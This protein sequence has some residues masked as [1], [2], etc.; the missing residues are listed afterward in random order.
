M[1][2]FVFYHGP[3]ISLASLLTEPAHSLIHQSYH[4]KER[5]EPLNGDGYGVAW[6]PEVGER[7]EPVIFKEVSPAWS[8]VNL[9]SLAPAIASDCIAA[10]VRAASPGLGVS[11]FNC[12]PFSH[13]NLTFM[14]NGEV[15]EI[16]KIRRE[17]L[18]RLDDSLFNF[19]RGTTDSEI[20][21]ALILQKLPASPDL[22]A[23][24]VALRDTICEVEDLLASV[25]SPVESTMNLCLSNGKVSVVSRYAT[26]GQDY[27]Q[28]L[29]FN[30][31][32]RYQ[33]VDGLCQM[34]DSEDDSR[35]VL[36]SS[37]PLSEES[38]WQK[39]PVNQILTVDEQLEVQLQAIDCARNLQSA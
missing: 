33:C 32:Q 35:A 22:S 23:M 6:Y 1:C 38:G 30:T 34:A 13:D 29:Y 27:S 20:L 9:R 37:E 24:T 17:L 18:S 8:S 3:A 5:P 28:S 25:H 11:Q 7:P 14:H 2:R 19:V 12:H 26:A 21:F 36:I 4:A 15:A 39:V 10:H 16:A 31:G